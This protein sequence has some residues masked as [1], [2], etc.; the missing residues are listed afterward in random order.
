MMMLTEWLAYLRAAAPENKP[1]RDAVASA[2]MQLEI[3]TDP[4]TRA[5]SVEYLDNAVIAADA[6]LYAY[7]SFVS[8][9]YDLL[10]DASGN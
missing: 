6:N 2:T 8:H 1:L 3:F 10:S 9:Q 5:E 7:R 4:T